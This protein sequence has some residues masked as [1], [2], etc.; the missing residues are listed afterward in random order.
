M[1]KLTD[2][3]MTILKLITLGYDNKQ[4]SKNVLFLSVFIQ[5]KHISAL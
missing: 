3:E 1:E 5:L 2:R 4:I